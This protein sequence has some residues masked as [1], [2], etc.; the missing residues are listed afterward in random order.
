MNEPND[1]DDVPLW[2]I[3]ASSVMGIAVIIATLLI[4]T[5]GK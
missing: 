4:V 3:I 2:W 5:A 1:F